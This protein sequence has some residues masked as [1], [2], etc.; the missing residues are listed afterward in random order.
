MHGVLRHEAKVSI[1][2]QQ[3]Q[4]QQD[5]KTEVI[6]EPTTASPQ[7]FSQAKT[8]FVRIACTSYP[9]SNLPAVVGSLPAQYLG[10]GLGPI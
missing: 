4:D 2:V 8:A 6:V 1:S 5:G 9:P 7:S 3:D 10:R